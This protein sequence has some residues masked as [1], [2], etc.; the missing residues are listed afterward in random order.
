MRV[1]TLFLKLVIVGA[2]AIVILIALYLVNNVISDRQN[3]RDAASASIAE[4]YATEQR[5]LGPTLVQPYRQTTQT[6]RRTTRA[7]R[8]RGTCLLCCRPKTGPRTMTRCE[9]H[10]PARIAQSGMPSCSGNWSAR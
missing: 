4:S 3:Y 1:A 7:S 5:L 9:A 2:L 8:G 10:R 6:P